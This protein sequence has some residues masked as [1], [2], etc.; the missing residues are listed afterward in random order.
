MTRP[1]R[2]F[3]SSLGDVPDERLRTTPV[4]A[5]LAREFRRSSPSR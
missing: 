5:N 2:I 4:I 3:I 1:L